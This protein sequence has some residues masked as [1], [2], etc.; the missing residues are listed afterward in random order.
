[1]PK[2][3][4]LAHRLDRDTSG[5]LV[6]GRHRQALIRLGELFET[7]QVQKTYL[8]IV[9]GAPPAME[10]VIRRPILKSGKGKM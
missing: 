10:G 1:L 4:A 2:P 8:A 5:C 3:P 7:Q 6:L 9:V